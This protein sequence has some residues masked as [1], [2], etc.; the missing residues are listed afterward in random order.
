MRCVCSWTEGRST[1]ETQISTAPS[2]ASSST[3]TEFNPCRVQKIKKVKQNATTNIH[4]DTLTLTRTYTYANWC[5]NTE[6]QCTHKNM[7]IDEYKQAH[8]HTLTCIC[9][10]TFWNCSLQ[11][12]NKWKSKING[13]K[14]I[15]AN[16]QLLVPFAYKYEFQNMYNIGSNSNSTLWLW[17]I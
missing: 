13:I 7:H 10:K 1:E 12:S 15:F 17:N 2:P 6:M 11:Q 8:T 9:I 16:S 14:S 5:T 4:I 3:Q